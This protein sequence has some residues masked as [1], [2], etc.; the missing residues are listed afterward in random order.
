MWAYVQEVRLL[1]RD[2]NAR[3]QA[4]SRRAD[5]LVRPSTNSAMRVLHRSVRWDLY[6]LQIVVRSVYNF[7]CVHHDFSILHLSLLVGPTSDNVRHS[8]MRVLI[9]VAYRAEGTG[10]NAQYLH[11]MFAALRECQNSN[12]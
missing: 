3:Q 8:V 10:C 7:I 9:T 2:E 11:V 12:W 6:S 1:L 5:V 4:S